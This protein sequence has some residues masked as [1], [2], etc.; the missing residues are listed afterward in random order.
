MSLPHAADKFLPSFGAYSAFLHDFLSGIEKEFEEDVDDEVKGVDK[1]MLPRIGGQ[2]GIHAADVT[3]V[4]NGANR[5]QCPLVDVLKTQVQGMPTD[6]DSSWK[7]SNELM[8]NKPY[9][10]TMHCDCV[11]PVTQYME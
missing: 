7:D 8:K 9:Q 10:A 6:W 5:F 2:V 1:L 4:D 11:T 3:V